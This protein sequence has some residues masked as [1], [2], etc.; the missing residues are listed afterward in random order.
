V[1]VLDTESVLLAFLRVGDADTAVAF[2]ERFGLLQNRADRE[3]LSNWLL[4]VMTLNLT[5]ALYAALEDA[6]AGDVSTLPAVLA[7]HRKLS[8]RI[9]DL[10]QPGETDVQSADL[11]MTGWLNTR[12]RDIALL[13]IPNDVL[14]PGAPMPFVFG[15]VPNT[16]LDVIWLELARSITAHD[17]MR[18]CALCGKPFFTKGTRARFCSASCANRDRQRRFVARKKAQRVTT[19]SDVDAG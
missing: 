4:E 9:A 2:A 19:T 8:P 3:L 12:L 14:P 10:E 7:M 6:R 16:L 15:A 17:R 13:V 18:Y 5:I 11:L 1:S